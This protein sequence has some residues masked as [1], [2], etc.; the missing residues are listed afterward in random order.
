MIIAEVYWKVI[1][2]WSL[3]KLNISD[4]FPFQWMLLEIIPY[5]IDF[6]FYF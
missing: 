3:H 1:G 2:A 6:P 5:I 4:F